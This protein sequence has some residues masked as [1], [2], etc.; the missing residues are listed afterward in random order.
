MLVLKTELK[1][2]ETQKEHLTVSPAHKYSFYEASNFFSQTAPSFH[3]GDSLF[4]I[5]EFQPLWEFYAHLGMP[6][7]MVQIIFSL[8]TPGNIPWLSPE[9]NALC[10]HSWC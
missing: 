10:F 4:I 3:S 6:V 7:M 1:F 8:R 2:L 5:V 9:M